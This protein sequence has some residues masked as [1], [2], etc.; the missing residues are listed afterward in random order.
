M[1]NFKQFFFGGAPRGGGVLRF[2]PGDAIFLGR[3]L[4]PLYPLW[5]CVPLGLSGSLAH[6]LMCS[7]A[8]GHLGSWGLGH[9]CMGS[10]CQRVNGCLEWGGVGVSGWVGGGHVLF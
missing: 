8:L 1:S 7:W 4:H 2:R 10:K 6:G 5:P 9:I 3:G